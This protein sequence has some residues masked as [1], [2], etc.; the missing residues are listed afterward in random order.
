MMSAVMIMGGLTTRSRLAFE[1]QK[2]LSE[3][4]QENALQKK[5]MPNALTT[6]I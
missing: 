2:G 3:L 5:Y 6:R 1:K 4:L